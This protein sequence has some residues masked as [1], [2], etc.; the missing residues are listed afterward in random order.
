M[1]KFLKYIKNHIILLICL[2]LSILIVTMGIPFLI[3]YSFK[4]TALTSIFI[5]EWDAGD[6]LVYYGAMLSFFSTTLLSILA[7]WQN[8][9]IEEKNHIHTTLLEKMEK[10]KN[11]PCLIID[12]ISWKQDAKTLDFDIKNVS[13]NIAHNIR[14]DDFLIIDENKGEKG[15]IEK[16]FEVRYL[17]FSAS[18]HIRLLNLQI[19]NQTDHICFNIYYSDKFNEIHKCA[20][21]SYF[22]DIEKKPY[23]EMREIMF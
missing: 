12:N 9:I 21:E 17:G 4:T 15:K 1:Q 18:Y 16:T 14:A 6:A 7:L 23:F 19:G 13:E 22:E 5:A 8:H 11:A 20:V 3:N 10:E 2:V